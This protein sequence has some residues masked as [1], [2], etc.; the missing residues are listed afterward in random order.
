MVVNDIARTD[1]GFDTRENEVTLLRRDGLEETIPRA[2][3]SQVA[4]RILDEV[5]RLRTT[6]R[7]EDD[8]AARTASVGATT[9]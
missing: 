7:G 8:G 9:P 2:D 3:K 1:I 4:D 6:T 5:Q